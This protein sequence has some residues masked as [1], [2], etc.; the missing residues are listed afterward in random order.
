[1]PQF[2]GLAASSPDSVY[3]AISQNDNHGGRTPQGAA[4]AS[5]DDAGFWA[6]MSGAGKSK[7]RDRP[8][9]LERGRRRTRQDQ[10]SR[11]AVTPVKLRTQGIRTNE[12]NLFLLPDRFLTENTIQPLT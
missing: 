9:R 6:G 4:R 3:R 8:R 7:R 10:I 5:T 12:E 11:G 2:V 1:M